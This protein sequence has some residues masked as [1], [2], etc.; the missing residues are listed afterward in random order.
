[1]SGGTPGNSAPHHDELPLPDFD[2]LPLGSLEGRIRSLDADGLT[3][4][5]D[6]ERA[7]GNRLPVTLV[8]ERRLE[9]VRGGA[10]LSGGSPL[11]ATPEL[12]HAPASSGPAVVEA[13]ESAP[14]K[15]GAPGPQ[16]GSGNRVGAPGGQ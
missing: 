12:Q 8:L 2:H 3:A 5:L 16:G 15:E 11:A 14:D 6:Y 7:H 1:M 10:E 13:P 9:Q 4:L